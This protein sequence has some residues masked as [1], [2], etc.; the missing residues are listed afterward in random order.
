MGEEWILLVV[1]ISNHIERYPHTTCEYLKIMILGPYK[2]FMWA[3][4]EV[5]FMLNW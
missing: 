2:A 1:A 3:V 4:L 5:R